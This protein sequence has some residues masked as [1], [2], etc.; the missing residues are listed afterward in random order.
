M[1]LQFESIEDMRVHRRQ[2]SGPGIVLSGAVYVPR[3]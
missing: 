3:T 2:Q 1:S